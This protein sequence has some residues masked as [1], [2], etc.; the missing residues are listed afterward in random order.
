MFPTIDEWKIDTNT[1]CVDEN[2]MIVI[3]KTLEEHFPHIK[4]PQHHYDGAQWHYFPSECAFTCVHFDDNNLCAV[5]KSVAKK[6][7]FMVLSVISP[8]DGQRRLCYNE[9]R[10]Q[11]YWGRHADILTGNLNPTTPV[12]W[13]KLMK[14]IIPDV[15]AVQMSLV[16]DK[17]AEKAKEI[18]SKHYNVQVSSKPSEVY[19]MQSDFKSCMVGLDKEK[20]LIYDDI[21]V[22]S[23]AYI[24]GEDNLLKARALL[25]E[26]TYYKKPMKIMDRIYYHDSYYLAAMVKWANEHGY[27]HK[28]RQSMDWYTFTNAN[29]DVK[30]FR[31]LRIPAPNIKHR[32]IDTPYIDTFCKL[33]VDKNEEVYL[34]MK[35]A[36]PYRAVGIIQTYSRRNVPYILRDMEAKDCANCGHLHR[37]EN[38]QHFLGYDTYYR[39][40]K[41]VPV[42]KSCSTNLI[43]CPI[44]GKHHIWKNLSGHG[45]Y[46]GRYVS[47]RDIDNKKYSLVICGHCFR[48]IEHLPDNEVNALWKKHAVQ[49]LI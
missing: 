36:R 11:K 25:H 7:I 5:P 21:E 22:T 33:C 26:T 12:K 20:F 30:Q 17:L 29:N 14:E 34:A 24:V 19:T 28:T 49:A 43:P 15:D 35:G 41:E 27:W 32:Y 38:F 16:C 8:N 23:I 6:Q 47:I 48:E 3:N 13:G 4:V 39:S 40:S 31:S 46:F 42:C 44:C 9:E 18:L 1:F 10:A 37:K 45:N 2:T